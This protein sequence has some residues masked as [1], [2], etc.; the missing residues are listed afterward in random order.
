MYPQTCKNIGIEGLRRQRI[1]N[2]NI[3]DGHHGDPRGGVC[4]RHVSERGGGG[5]GKTVPR[6]GLLHHSGQFRLEH[7]KAAIRHGCKVPDVQFLMPSSGYNVRVKCAH[8][9][10]L[11]TRVDAATLRTACHAPRIMKRRTHCGVK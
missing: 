10:P 11:S 6:V 2:I 8:L 1:N 5:Q 9:L 3:R 4:W 7:P